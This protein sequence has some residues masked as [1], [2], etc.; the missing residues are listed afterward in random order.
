MMDIEFGTLRSHLDIIRD[1]LAKE[2]AEKQHD[3]SQDKPKSLRKKEKKMTQQTLEVADQAA[4]DSIVQHQNNINVFKTLNAINVNKQTEKKG[5]FTYLSWA[6]AVSELL[7]AYPKAE[8]EVKRFNNLPYLKTEL[9]YFVEV[10]LNI[11]GVKRSQIHPV[12]DHHNNPIKAPNA[13]QINTSIQRAL[14][15]AISLHGLGLYI[16]AGEDLPE[17]DRKEEKKTSK[18]PT[19]VK[20]ILD[21]IVELSLNKSKQ[22]YFEL[23][24][25]K[26][27]DA[28]PEEII[29][30]AKEMNSNDFSLAITNL[31]K[32][33]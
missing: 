2:S 6:W 26:Y 25:K 1:D 33:L 18:P 5:R 4:Q 10:E 8:W 32:E 21:D 27:G 24:K 17:I 3:E 16:Y 23:L 14:A 20:K 29:N 15:K 9:G 7:K 13:F 30:A 22:R 19:K 31:E 28:I 11:N 12:L